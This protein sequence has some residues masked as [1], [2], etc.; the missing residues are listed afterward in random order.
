MLNKISD[1]QRSILEAAALREDRLLS[2]PANL[3]GGSAKRIEAKL[4]DAGWAKE[5][6][7]PKGAPVWRRDASA[8]RA[9]ALKLTTAGM[10]AI[11]TG[12]DELGARTT[13]PSKIQVAQEAAVERATA[14]RRAA[15]VVEALPTENKDPSIERQNDDS[16]VARRAPRPGSKLDR[17]LGLLRAETGATLAELIAATGWLPHSARAVLTGLRKRGYQLTLAR[18]ERGGASVYRVAA[19]VG[20]VKR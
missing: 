5:V 2:L 10:K 7:A 15:N 13:E 18:G 3:K 20:E 1:V 12:D 14:R 9:F 4:I 17:V 19:S 11:A 16:A 6:K 8:G